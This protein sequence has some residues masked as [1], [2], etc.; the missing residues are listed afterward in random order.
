LKWT[1]IMCFVEEIV[2]QK[3]HSLTFHM[4]NCC[5]WR[6]SRNAAAIYSVV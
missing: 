4:K 3:L 1:A 6:I 2:K 5:I